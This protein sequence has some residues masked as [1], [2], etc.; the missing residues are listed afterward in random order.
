MDCT[1]ISMRI[2]IRTAVVAATVAVC[3]AGQ[4][5]AAQTHSPILVAMPSADGPIARAVARQLATPA[6]RA[7]VAKLTG[8]DGA[9]NHGTP[10]ETRHVDAA[11]AARVSK[12]GV[13]GAVIG[14]AAG[15]VLGVGLAVNYGTR[16]CGGSCDD[17]RVMIGVSLIGIPIA[18]GLAGYHIAK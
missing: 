11:G 4:S 12:R 2:D 17:E 18:G 8:D 1:L 5:L 13:I 15:A 10:G 7:P 9:M 16:D 3:A 6:H 14:A